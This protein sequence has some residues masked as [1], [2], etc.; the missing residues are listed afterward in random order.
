[1][2]MSYNLM[3]HCNRCSPWCPPGDGHYNDRPQGSIS[4]IRILKVMSQL[5][6]GGSCNFLHLLI[7]AWRQISHLMG[8]HWCAKITL[9][10]IY[11]LYKYI[12][13]PRFANC[14]LHMHEWQATTDESVSTA[15]LEAPSPP[16][17]S[18]AAGLTAAN[19]YQ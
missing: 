1:M 8:Q 9:M 10:L 14:K 17:H 12:G 11:F 15:N 2:H 3:L 7:R 6:H 18:K 16:R 19:N 13:K 5:P 4:I